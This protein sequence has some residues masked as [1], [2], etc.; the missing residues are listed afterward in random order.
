M[1]KESQQFDKMVNTPI[2]KL[3]ITLGI[4]TIIS[5]LI[6]AIY[7]IADT[8]FVSQLG[9]AVSGAVSVV[10]PLQA[11]IQ[12][13]GFTL[14]MGGGSVISSLLG[15]KKDKEAQEVGSSSFYLALVLGV[16]ICVI[17]LIFMGPLLN[18]LGATENGFEHAKNYAKYIVIAAPIMTGSFVLNNLLRSEGKSKLAMIGLTIGGLLNIGLDPL[19]INTFNM[20]ISGAAIATLV[21][22]TISFTILLSM[23][24]FKKSIIKLSPYAISKQFAVYSEILKVGFPSFCRQGFVCLATILLNNQASTYGEMVG[25]EVNDAA[26]SAMGIVGKIVTVIFT[27]SLGIGQGYQPVCGYNYHS[28]RYERVKEATIFTFSFMTCVMLVLSL[29]FFIFAEKVMNLFIDDS[30]VVKFGVKALRWQCFA[31]P[32]VSVNTICNMTYQ[33]TKQKTKATILS[34]CRQGIFFIPL[35]LLLP[36]FIG[37]DGVIVSQSIA[38]LITCVFSI[39][40]FISLIKEI[41]NKIKNSKN[42]SEL[43]E[44]I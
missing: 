33:S 19:L 40:F 37:L 43:V 22:Q 4:P 3:V 20:G 18:L 23:F 25:P 21:S 1:T 29:F 10:F 2:K 26:Q 27:V 31:M 15:E 32:F 41:N 17:S 11:V 24:V 36:L 39:F 8:F 9:K 34:C 6:T 44:S 5:M 38:D 28:K 13:I 16:L 42:E 12:A 35:I 7:N 14:G 30:M